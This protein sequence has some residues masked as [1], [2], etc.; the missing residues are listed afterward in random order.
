MYIYRM[1]SNVDLTNYK[2]RDFAR[3]Q[4]AQLLLEAGGKL[5][6]RTQGGVP[7]VVALPPR[8]VTSAGPAWEQAVA[9]HRASP[10]CH[11]ISR[12]LIELGVQHE[13]EV[14]SE[15]GKVV[16]DLAVPMEGQRRLAIVDVKRNETSVNEPYTMGGYV[17]GLG[18]M[19]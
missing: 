15:D 16:I 19:L 1:L 9:K 11:S 8:V 13:V 4:Q 10:M 12:V 6:T 17:V 2:P 14:G 5:V 18:K 3:L 7:G